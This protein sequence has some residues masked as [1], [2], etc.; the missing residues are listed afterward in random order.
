MSIMT[1]LVLVLFN[2]L[3]MAGAGSVMALAMGWTY[4]LTCMQNT[5]AT[6]DSRFVLGAVGLVMALIFL[7]GLIWSMTTD[8]KLETVEVIKSETGEVSISVAAAKVIIMKAVKQVE[9]VKE[10]IPT[11][12]HSPRGLTVKLHAMIN[13]DHS[14][15]E[16]SKSLQDVVRDALDKYG[17]LQVPV[18]KVLV[19]DFNTGSK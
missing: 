14:V 8:H 10:V 3:G 1:R 6:A 9:G 2:L 15:P 19:D 4:P 7:L 17:G 16:V 11:V 12:Y 5:I 18:I 13:P